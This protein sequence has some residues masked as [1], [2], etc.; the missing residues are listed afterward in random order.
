MSEPPPSKIFGAIL[1]ALGVA[2]FALVAAN[3]HTRRL[4]GRDLRSLLLLASLM[5]VGGVALVSSRWWVKA[6]SSVILA[7]AG[8]WV[9]IHSLLVLP[10][11]AALPGVLIGG[12]L[13]FPL[14]HSVRGR[15][16]FK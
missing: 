13:L 7:G 11:D 5:M 15:T 8:C 16:G 3:D 12:A 9:I 10:I 14:L 4:G 2:Q 6:V 1:I